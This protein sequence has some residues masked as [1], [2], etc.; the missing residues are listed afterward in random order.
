MFVVENYKENRTNAFK[1]DDVT[2]P[3]HYLEG[4]DYE[5][6][7][8]IEDWDLGFYLGNV[9]KYIA[10]AGRKNDM[11]EDLKKARQYLDWEIEKI[12]KKRSEKES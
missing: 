1:F 4:R 12:E 9:V 10:R 3:A 6:R 11:L 5:P 2:G 8:V 7:K